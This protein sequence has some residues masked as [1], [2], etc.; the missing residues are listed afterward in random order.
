MQANHIFY[1]LKQQT[2]SLPTLN[3]VTLPELYDTVYRPS[4]TLIEDFLYS[5]VYLFVGPPKIGKSFFMAQLAYHVATG[6]KLWNFDVKS[7]IFL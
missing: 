2:N 7:S 3:T 4:L 6:T 5:G 1:P